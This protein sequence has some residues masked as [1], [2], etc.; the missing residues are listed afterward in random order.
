[1][2]SY[3]CCRESESIIKVFISGF[4][5]SIFAMTAL[6]C[7]V[8][9]FKCCVGK[10]FVVLV[11]ALNVAVS[12]VAVPILSFMDLIVVL[13]FDIS[14]CNFSSIEFL[15]VESLHILRVSHHGLPNPRM[16]FAAFASLDSC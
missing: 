1:M 2:L 14:F 10:R 16:L 13:V 5:P 7:E 6:K 12:R 11:T 3:F 15:I 8:S 9:G 4:Q